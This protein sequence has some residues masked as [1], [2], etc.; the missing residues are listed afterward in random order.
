MGPCR[1][2][3]SGSRD[4]NSASKS[5]TSQSASWARAFFN[6]SF[7]HSISKKVEKIRSV[8][9]NHSPWDF[10]GLWP[11]FW[12]EQGGGGGEE[13]SSM[14]PRSCRNVP[15]MGFVYWIS[16]IKFHGDQRFWYKMEF[17]SLLAKLILSGFPVWTARE[18]RMGW[19]G[20]QALDFTS[21]AEG[22]T[23]RGC[24]EAGV[25]RKAPAVLCD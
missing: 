11:C 16:S 3:W 10:R 22:G 17:G 20:D 24:R 19:G 21:S 4:L 2:C 13:K 18:R 23:S 5:L 9:S 12:A 8:L 7:S 15:F 6:L 1:L 14:H 25:G